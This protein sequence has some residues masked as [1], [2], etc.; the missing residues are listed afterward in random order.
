MGLFNWLKR[1]KNRNTMHTTYVSRR[2]YEELTKNS[3][4]QTYERNESLTKAAR[5]AESSIRRTAAPPSSPSRSTGR[6]S[7]DAAIWST[8]YGSSDS[9]SSYSSGCSD[10][11]SS[12]SS[13]SSSDSGSSGSCDS[14]GF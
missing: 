2:T 11:G 5:R 1:R 8:T 10:S 7:N 4:P 3:A 12:G 9:G 6:T 14:G 13:S